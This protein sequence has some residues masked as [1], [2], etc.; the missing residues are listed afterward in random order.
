ML[1]VKA[2]PDL[3]TTDTRRKVAT[4]LQRLS[5]LRANNDSDRLVCTDCSLEIDQ[6]LTSVG[7]FDRRWEDYLSEYEHRRLECS[8]YLRSA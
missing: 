8:G 5:Y 3:A 4:N 6:A 1:Q 2:N 7:K